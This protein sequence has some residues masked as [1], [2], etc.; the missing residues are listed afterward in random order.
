MKGNNQAYKLWLSLL[1]SP[2]LLQ[3][4]LQAPDKGDYITRTVH[5]IHEVTVTAERTKQQAE[6]GSLQ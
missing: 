3:L 2:L 4:E 1:C 5:K 6:P